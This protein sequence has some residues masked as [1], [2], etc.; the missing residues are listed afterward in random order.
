MTRKASKVDFRVTKKE[1][2]MNKK[3]LKAKKIKVLT[4]KQEI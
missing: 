4:I 3:I 1:L 2:E